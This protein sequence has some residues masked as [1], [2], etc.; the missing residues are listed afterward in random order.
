[1]PAGNAENKESGTNRTKTTPA[2]S[3]VP[4]VDLCLLG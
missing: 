2:W 4:A 1:M 3:V